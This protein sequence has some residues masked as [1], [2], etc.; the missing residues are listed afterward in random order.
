MTMFLKAISHGC[1]GLNGIEAVSNGVQSFEAPAAGR[2]NTTMT[3]LKF[4][5]SSIFA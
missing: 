3:I 4:L 2:A 5:L 1:A